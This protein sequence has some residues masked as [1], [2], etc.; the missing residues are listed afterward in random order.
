MSGIRPYMDLSSHYFFPD[1]KKLVCQYI[2]DEKMSYRRFAANHKL[3]KSRIGK[4]MS[5]WKEFKATGRDKF[6]H[7]KGGR[8]SRIDHDGSL[9][10]CDYLKA[11]RRNQQAPTVSELRTKIN[12]EVMATGT[13]KGIANSDNPSRSTLWR[14]WKSHRCEEG[15]CQ[16]KTHARILNEGDPRNVYTMACMMWAFCAILAACMCFNWDATQ[17]Y[18]SD[19]ITDTAVYIKGDSCHIPLTRESSGGLG[20]SIKYYHFH[21]AAGEAGP[22]VYI[23]ADD[24]MSE[25]EFWV[26]SVVSLGNSTEVGSKG[27]LCFCKTRNGNDA[28]YEWF[29][30]TVVVPFV[31]KV[32]E[33]H[34]EKNDDGTD[35]RAFVMCDGEESQIRVF[36]KEE[37]RQSLNLNLIDLGKTPASCSAILQ[38]SDVSMFFKTTK[39]LLKN[40]QTQPYKNATLERSLTTAF[41]AYHQRNGEN[42]RRGISPAMQSKIINSLQ[43]IVFVIHKT[44]N[45]DIIIKGYI[46][47]GQNA[48]IS[49]DDNGEAT[50]TKYEQCIK[51][52][53]RQLTNGEFQIMRENLPHFVSIMRQHGKITEAQMDEKGIPNY[54]HLDTDKK[55]K[56][57]RALHKQRATVMNSEDVVSQFIDYQQRRLTHQAEMEHRRQQRDA[58]L[59]QRQIAKAAKDAEKRRRL[60]MTEE[61]KRAEAS[62]KRRA[63]NERKRLE[64]MEQQN[65]ERIQRDNQIQNQV[66]NEQIQNQVQNEQ[67]PYLQHLTYL[68]IEENLIDWSDELEDSDQEDDEQS[69]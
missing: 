16:M 18:M 30:K 53:T 65:H 43:Q 57:E 4:W 5:R 1:D 51:K 21:N 56:N 64:R 55:P 29:A 19:D 3:S 61:E 26:T 40:S 6:S 62:A 54:N 59:M 38:S 66:Q 15:K 27:Y 69:V 10:L 42:T 47:C 36:Q 23:I 44:L 32:R 8:P 11:G 45:P 25:E 7:D 41:H 49:L 63:T 37:I 2:V 24:S 17:F 52:C 33:I 48:P 58:T 31:Q 35:M 28:F 39:Q 14:I 20:I 67:V 68:N 22:A 9:A 46:D 50:F 12:T 34:Q 60:T 13:R